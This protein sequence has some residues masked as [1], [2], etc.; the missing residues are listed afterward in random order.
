M[1][2]PPTNLVKFTANLVLHFPSLSDPDLGDDSQIEG[3][4][5]G[6]D[7]DL[8]AAAVEIKSWLAGSPDLGGGGSR[9]Q[10]PLTC[11]AIRDYSAG[12]WRW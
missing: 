4:S 11:R 8:V 5:R 7:P 9:N 10:G 2:I 1:S 6:N 12:D 3:S